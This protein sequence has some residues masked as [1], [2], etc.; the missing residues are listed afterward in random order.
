[1]DGVGLPQAGDTC[2]VLKTID[3]EGIGAAVQLE[4]VCK[5]G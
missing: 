5:V 1:V 4:Y 3:S 2:S